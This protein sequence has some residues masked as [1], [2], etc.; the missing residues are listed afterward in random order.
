MHLVANTTAHP[1]LLSMPGGASRVTV[2]DAVLRTLASQ[3]AA[4]RSDSRAGH[5]VVPQSRRNSSQPYATAGAAREPS[6]QDQYDQLWQTI[7][8][9][10]QLPRARESMSDDE[11]SMRLKPASNS[12]VVPVKTGNQLETPER[13]RLNR[14]GLPSAAT[15]ARN[16]GRG[17]SVASPVDTSMSHFTSASG[18]AVEP[19]E[20][21]QRMISA[22]KTAESE[23]RAA[24][25]RRPAKPPPPASESSAPIRIEAAGSEGTA[26]QLALTHGDMS[27]MNDVSRAATT[28]ACD[29]LQSIHTELSQRIAEMQAE[30]DLLSANNEMLANL[31]FRSSREGLPPDSPELRGS[32]PPHH[33]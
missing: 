18:T 28:K 33:L 30:M 26:E 8:T 4:S 5:V 6:H 32:Q 2:I 22:A 24:L 17:D 21:I 23:L 1:A 3:A 9:I 15:P 29:A 7:S 13:T 25:Q 10:S 16:S 14:R 31:L 27:A 11:R 20:W 19:E 12:R